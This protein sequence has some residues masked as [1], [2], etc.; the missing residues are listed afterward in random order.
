V[1]AGADVRRR[2]IWGGRGAVRAAVHGGTPYY[3][4]AT[5]TAAAALHM[6]RRRQAAC[7]FWGLCAFTPPLPPPPPLFHLQLF[8]TPLA[9]LLRA[10][11]L[12]PKHGRAQIYIYI[13]IHRVCMCLPL[14]SLTT[15][16]HRRLPA[17]CFDCVFCPPRQLCARNWS[18]RFCSPTLS[19]VFDKSTRFC[20]VVPFGKNAHSITLPPRSC[21]VAHTFRCYQCSYEKE[22]KFRKKRVRAR[23]QCARGH[24][25][26]FP[27]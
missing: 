8:S 27:I 15:P 14:P 1:A 17:A 16:K 12:P 22:A 23:A 24:G 10:R 19:L 5:Q 20:A 18:V 7:F 11:S 21:A 4:T 25:E 6:A 26:P 3:G 2:L 9:P 13:Y